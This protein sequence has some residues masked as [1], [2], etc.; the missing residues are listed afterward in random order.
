MTKFIE[1]AAAAG[2]FG[3]DGGGL[4]PGRGGD[5]LEGAAACTDMESPSSC[6]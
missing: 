2:S 4:V 5:G 1:P 3:I 6:E